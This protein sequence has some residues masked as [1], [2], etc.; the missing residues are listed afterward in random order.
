MGISLELAAVTMVVN[1]ADDLI[2]NFR[3]VVKLFSDDISNEY[4]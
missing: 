2:K 3:L 4:E 1:V